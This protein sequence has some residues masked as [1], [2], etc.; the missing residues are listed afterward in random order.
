[1]LRPSKHAHPDRTV[2]NVAMLLLGRLRTRRHEGF[3]DLKAFA[4]KAVTGGDVLF[5][6]SLNFL[7]L[8]GLVDYHAKTDAIEYV[9]PNEGL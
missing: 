3:D 2:V 9:G 6:P 7:F 4:R 1:M 8:L 5:M